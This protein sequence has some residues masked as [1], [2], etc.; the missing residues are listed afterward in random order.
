MSLLKK[1]VIAASVLLVTGIIG[2]LVTLP[3]KM[4]AEDVTEVKNLPE[5][6]FSNIKV[7]ANNAK[8]ELLPVSNHSATAEL[9]G[10]D[11]KKYRFHADVK[12]DTLVIEVKDKRKLLFEMDFM[13]DRSIKVLV[14]EKDYRLIELK[15]DNGRIETKSMT[16]KELTAETNNGKVKMDDVEALTVRAESDNGRI[17]ARNIRSS[18]FQA[19]TNNGRIELED[20]EGTIRAGSNNGRVSLASEEIDRD[21]ELTTDNGKIEIYTK[22]EPKNAAFHVST[23]NGKIEIFDESY[24]G[25]VLHGKGDHTITLNSHNGDIT[26]SR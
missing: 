7:H 10:M 14:P 20:V 9:S 24:R 21:I 13:S 3:S 26:V 25:S 6:P 5:G 8:I 17:E 16:A 4:A 23:G 12:D 19:R 22:E 11:E 1:L 15:S 2:S 18:S